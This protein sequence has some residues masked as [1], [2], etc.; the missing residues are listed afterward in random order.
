MFF[1][2][3][4]M[5]TAGDSTPAVY[6]TVGRVDVVADVTPA[7]SEAC[8]SEATGESLGAEGSR[9]KRH[10]HVTWML[11]TCFAWLAAGCGSDPGTPLRH[12]AADAPADTTIAAAEV[13][14]SPDTAEVA[15]DAA[16]P[17]DAPPIQLD[18]AGLPDAPA[19]VDTAL[20][21]DAAVLP[22]DTSATETSNIDAAG[23]GDVVINPALGD[24]GAVLVGATGPSMAFRLTNDGSQS[25][26]TL[27]ASVSSP[28]FVIT[29]DTCSGILLA[30]G[31]SCTVAVALRPTSVGAKSATLTI[32]DG[33][34]WV[35]KTLTGT[36]IT[37]GH[38]TPVP[39]A[40][41]FGSVAV[42]ATS[43]GQ[44]VTL[45]NVGGGTSGA[46]STSV[47]GS[48]RAAFSVSANTCAGPLAPGASCSF[49][50]SFAPTAKGSAAATV[51]VTD[52]GWSAAVALAGLGV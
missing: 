37:P 34:S 36:G 49:T 24:L 41:D 29:S 32:T 46:L 47:S 39:S 16:L 12:D 40:I 17:P 31:M 48:E 9:M 1:S 7:S 38:P 22:L 4:T 43:P 52:G 21:W 18:A 19:L 44:A 45:A 8:S 33:G 30:P 3:S 26:G 20:P 28:E 25:T 5:S 11:A 6:P 50:V 27:T 15:Q 23:T 51:I 10:R 2:S 14:P 42:G 13:A 35:L